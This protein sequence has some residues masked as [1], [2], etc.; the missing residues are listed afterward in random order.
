M[1]GDLRQ[2]R[3]RLPA[4]AFEEQHEARD[5]DGA[6]ARRPGPASASARQAGTTSKPGP[7]RNNRRSIRHHSGAYSANAA[8]TWRRQR[9][10]GSSSRSRAL[11]G[12]CKASAA[13]GG[14]PRHQPSNTIRSGRCVTRGQ[15]AGGRRRSRALS[16]RG[17]VMAPPSARPRRASSVAQASATSC[18][19]GGPRVAS[20]GC[21]A[22]ASRWRSTRAEVEIVQRQGGHGQP[23]RP[24][25]RRPAAGPAS[26]CRCPAGRRC[27]TPAAGPGWRGPGRGRA[28]RNP[29][30][31][32]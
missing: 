16:K 3:Q 19:P 21:T 20:R 2:G 26:I 22:R 9:P 27:R 4:D 14:T 17:R 28:R 1:V 30:H 7:C 25:R 18:V 5:V 15:R 12:A 32:L 24:G 6:A 13:S 23:L 11:T 8:L 10:S 29:A 31:S